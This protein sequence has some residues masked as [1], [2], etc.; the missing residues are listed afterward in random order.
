MEYRE[1]KGMV[2][3][4]QMDV[5]RRTESEPSAETLVQNIFRHVSAWKPPL[6]RKVTYAGKA[7]GKNHL[8]SAGI[9]VGSYDGGNLSPDQILVIGRGGAEKL[10]N[11]S[12]AIAS[13]V[14]AGGNLLGIGLHPAETDQL[15]PFKVTM[16]SAEHIASFFEPPDA[17]SLLAGVG[18]ADVHNRDPSE[19]PLIS[20]GAAIL[21]DGIL[22]KT[23]GAN[24]VFCQMVPWHFD[25]NK[26]SNLKRTHRRAAFVVS[27]LL[28]NMGGAGAT[29]VLDRF[30][31]S[32]NAAKPETRWFDGLYLDRP[33]EWDDPYRHFRW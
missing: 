9:T 31:K 26:S 4:C 6:S 24:V 22:A 23:D 19:F 17:A 32:V 5:T 15:L 14:K 2:L 33:E 8:E 1:G 16:K 28:A 25:G 20:A 30:H 10:R 29:P 13:F 21:G 11:H 12:T 27:R 7:A 18:P 3:F